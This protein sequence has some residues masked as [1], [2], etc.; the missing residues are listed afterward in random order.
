M[1]FWLLQYIDRCVDSLIDKFTIL[2][3]LKEDGNTAD[4]CKILLD[5]KIAIQKIIEGYT[6]V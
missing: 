5:H 4:I 3:T 6:E 2:H 1:K